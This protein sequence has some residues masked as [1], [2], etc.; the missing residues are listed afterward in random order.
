MLEIRELVN[1][2]YEVETGSEGVAFKNI[3]RYNDVFEPIEDE[4]PFFHVLRLENSP[5][6]VGVVKAK[7]IDDFKIVEI[8]PVAIRPEFQV[9]T[10]VVY[11]KYLCITKTTFLQGQ[12]LGSRLFNFAESLA[13][14][15]QIRVVSCRSDLFPIYLKRGYRELYR[16]PAEK[17]I[18]P[19]YM[20]RQGLEFVVMQKN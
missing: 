7:M 18:P 10:T 11:H 9:N 19:Q 15:A 14:I 1:A 16:Y 4:L 20:T 2:A 3:T 17:T 5:K 12:G 8:G 6:I 13:S